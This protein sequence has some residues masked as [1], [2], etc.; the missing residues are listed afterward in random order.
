[1]ADS[2]RGWARTLETANEMTAELRED[3]WEVVTV[4]AAHVGPELPDDGETDRFGLVYVAPGDVADPL[5]DL[6][7]RGT[8]ES[9]RVF[10]RRSGSDRFVLTRVSDAD[11]RLA[12]L[13]A[14]TV[15]LARA[16]PLASLARE[17]GEMHSHVELLDGTQVASFTHDDP[18]A[19][20]PDDGA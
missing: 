11:R 8:F 17:R 1:M 19:F 2:A 5:A 4:R 10:S 9:Y 18:E 15:D 3:G 7:D 16:A 13:L 6:L 12:T 20:F 14:G